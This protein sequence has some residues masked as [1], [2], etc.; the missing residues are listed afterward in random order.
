[1][2]CSNLVAWDFGEGTGNGTDEVAVWVML[3]VSIGTFTLGS[4]Y[5]AY[6]LSAGEVI[7]G[8]FVGSLISSWIAFFCARKHYPY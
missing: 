8:V 1:M 3:G 6:G 2:N 4:S 7:G 5:I